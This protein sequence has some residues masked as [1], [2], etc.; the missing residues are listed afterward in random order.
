MSIFNDEKPKQITYKLSFDN[1]FD[2]SSQEI[3]MKST[4]IDGIGFNELMNGFRQFLLALSYP[5]E[6]ARHVTCLS[7]EDI[8]QLGYSEDDFGIVNVE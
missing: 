6:T 1:D 2:G 3:V 4:Y 7:K 8:E 5:E